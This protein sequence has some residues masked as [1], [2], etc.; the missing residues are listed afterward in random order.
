M[1]IYTYVSSAA[2][3]ANT[4]HARAGL[5]VSLI[6]IVFEVSYEL[7]PTL[8]VA[9][10]VLCTS[11]LSQKIISIAHEHAPSAELRTLAFT[12]EP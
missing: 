6:S 8:S 2:S 7:Y 4:G 10:R 1:S 3:A 9:C 12:G 5:C 11:G